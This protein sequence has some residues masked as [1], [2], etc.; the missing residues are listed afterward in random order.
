MT[1]F[2]IKTSPGFRT[3]RLKKGAA[4]IPVT[5]ASTITH[6]P[7]RNGMQGGPP[8]IGPVPQV[9]TTLGF[10]GSI[11]TLLQRVAGEDLAQKT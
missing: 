6:S 7:L 8:V 1:D 10:F 2:T 11:V 3:M 4:I 5:A 9:M